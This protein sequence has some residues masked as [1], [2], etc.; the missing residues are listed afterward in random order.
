MQTVYR[1]ILAELEAPH[2]RDMSAETLERFKARE[3]TITDGR[4]GQSSLLGQSRTPLILLFAT[5]G[6]VV[7]IACANIANLLLARSA[8]R[9][10]EMAVR[11]SLGA[12][13]RRLI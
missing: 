8:T 7:L 3:L 5:T 9:T 10:T 11:L 1:P 13:R 2:Q 12:G 4:R 6:L